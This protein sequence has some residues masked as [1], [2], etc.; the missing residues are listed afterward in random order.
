MHRAGAI[1]PAVTLMAATDGDARGL[2]SASDS[3]ERLLIQAL[4]RAVDLLEA[5]VRH[6][7]EN[8]RVLEGVNYLPSLSSP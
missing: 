2:H 5:F 7:D 1:A 3:R 8:P 6:V 4:E